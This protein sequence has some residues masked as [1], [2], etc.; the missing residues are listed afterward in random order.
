MTL[1]NQLIK[2]T[3]HETFLNGET[4]DPPIKVL[5]DVYYTE[6]KMDNADLSYI[7]YAQ[8]EVYFHYK[9]YETAIFKWENI[10][11]ELEPWA[12][13]NMGDAYFELG[14]LSA[15]EDLYKAIHTDS[16]V[17]NTEVL[18]QLFSL[19][20]EQGKPESA[21]KAI[22][23]AA[24]LNPDYPEVTFL[25]RSFFERNHDW[26]SAVELALTEGIRTQS[27]SW[28]DILNEYVV[29]GYTAEISPD[30]FIVGLRELYALDT[31]RFERLV[32]SLWDSYNI[33]GKYLSWV[34]AV[35]E[36]FQPIEGMR[37]SWKKL[38]QV[39]ND[40]Y[41]TLINGQYFI[42]E[43]EKL[44]PGLL[45]NWLKVAD[46]AHAALAS[47]AVLAWS[48]LFQNTIDQAAIA[49]AERLLSS[50]A[51]G[52]DG[53]QAGHELFDS[54]LQWAEKNDLK[55]A[56]HLNYMMD[57]LSDFNVRH[58]LL[59]GVSGSG[60][61]TLVN[62]VLGEALL[63]GPT[64]T[65][66]VIKDDDHYEIRKVAESGFEEISSFED[67]QSVSA[68][69][70]MP[71]GE[72]FL[73]ECRIPN[74]FLRETGIS[75]V[76][77]P[78]LSGTLRSG[79]EV[80]K[81]V[82]F[83]DGLI[84]VLNANAPYTER[85]RD[86]LL[87]IMDKAP[88]LPVH[89]L[90]NKI[91]AAY[92][93][94][95]AARIL[96]DTWARV[97]IHFPHAHIFAFS[98]HYES[99]QQLKDLSAFLQNAFR[100][101]GRETAR[102]G[103]ILHF[104]RKTIHYLLD[105]RVEME[106][107]LIESIKW[108]EEMSAKLNGAAHQVKDLEK[109]KISAIT[110]SFRKMKEDAKMELLETIP[111]LLQGCSSFIK[112]DSDFR[113]IHLA[114]NDEMNRRIQEYLQ[115]EILPEFYHSMKDWIAFSRDE[116]T[117]SQLFLDET[118]EGFNALYEEE[119][120][121]LEGDFKILDDWRRDADRMTSGI[122]FEEVNILL[123]FTPSQFLLKSAGK[124]FG[125]IPQNKSLLFNKYKQ[126]IESEDYTEA[127]ETIARK[128]LVQFELFEKALER[129]IALFFRGPLTELDIAMEDSQLEI[130]ES[131]DM[132]NKLKANPEMYE[133]P[134][135]L[136]ELRLRQYEWIYNVGSGAQ[137]IY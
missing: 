67:F 59:A 22:K 54:I 58:I 107:G 49:E 1:E 65:A 23:K 64:S 97:K 94:Q 42:N 56:H 3:F 130:R 81:Y 109:E 48:E 123:R 72:E 91:D 70:G 35:N 12:K 28:F 38:P 26:K 129:D 13:K 136:F 30:Y 122:Q 18:L 133:D 9:D 14:L 137:Y 45:V 96:D 15:A 101:Q 135:T 53:V 36:L 24:G 10:A 55:S 126:F 134:L 115:E 82:N 61:S 6:Q 4:S 31:L 84:F 32:V 52:V 21:D 128:F 86:I 127:A 93:D 76:D 75:F 112:E 125:A 117:Q 119:R 110:K 66:V 106:N 114:L 79:N 16:Q 74:A 40:A 34:K 68:S 5:G 8:A 118:S 88:G 51:P 44:I 111:A 103:K 41:F 77:T 29:Q 19:Y 7:R 47:A 121:K 73:I 27:V 108:N 33:Q 99:G 90:L 60:K 132:L 124:L 80:F 116:F 50:E 104:V 57:Q 131:Q 43:I 85:E 98:S 120:I 25:A 39:F 63:E 113:K 105:K 102:S 95:E 62:S 78:G 87:K 100:D 2:K 37:D 83:A 71:D 11:N 46:R 69:S 89:F 17:L 92:S 20:I